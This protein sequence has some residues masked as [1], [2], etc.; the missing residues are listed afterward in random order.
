[1]APHVFY[2]T[3]ELQVPSNL[4]PAQS[5][6]TSVNGIAGHSAAPLSI[7]VS[8]RLWAAPPLQTKRE[9]RAENEAHVTLNSQGARTTS[10]QRARPHVPG[11]R[12]RPRQANPAGAGAE[13]PPE[14][15]VQSLTQRSHLLITLLTCF[16]IY[17]YLPCKGTGSGVQAQ[18][19]RRSDVYLG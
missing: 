13:A 11:G 14:P 17:G 12:R 19:L 5:A 1:M 10:A 8:I 9:K 18:W 6:P 7:G 16:N 15:A 3:K 4:S 2:V